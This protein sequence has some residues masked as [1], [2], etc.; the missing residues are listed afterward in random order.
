MKRITRLI[1]AGPDKDKRVWLNQFG[2]WTQDEGQAFVFDD[3]EATKR[4]KRLAHAS[5][6]D[7]PVPLRKDNGDV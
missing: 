1:N 5:L 2:S 4:L 7:P 6:T 3:A